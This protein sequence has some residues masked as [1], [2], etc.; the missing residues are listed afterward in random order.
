[1]KKYVTLLIFIFG[2]AAIIFAIANKY[3]VDKEKCIGCQLCISSCPVEAI[4]MIDGKAVIDAKAC[5]GCG[6]CEKG[7]NENYKGCPVKAISQIEEKK[8]EIKKETIEKSFYKVITEGCIGCGLCISSCPVDA[9][10]MVDGKAI[11]DAKKCIDCGICARGNDKG[12]RGCPV[13]TIKRV[14]NSKK[15]K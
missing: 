14:D 6:I 8:E 2:L 7:D 1:M 10:K 12:Y 11:I 15:K 13:N 9:I 4:K 5:I 3:I